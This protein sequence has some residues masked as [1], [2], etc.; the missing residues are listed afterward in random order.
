MTAGARASHA[1]A[2]AAA[3]GRGAVRISMRPIRRDCRASGRGSASTGPW[4]SPN[5]AERVGGGRSPLRPAVPGRAAPPHVRRSVG[6]VAGSTGGPRAGNTAEGTSSRRRVC[7]SRVAR[8]AVG[9]ERDAGSRH[10]GRL[11]AGDLRLRASCPRDAPRAVGAGVALGDAAPVGRQR[12]L[13]A[14]RRDRGGSERAA[15]VSSEGRQVPRADRA[16]VAGPVRCP[17]GVG[18]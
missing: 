15:R 10:G 16:S 13:R 7:A 3:R 18:V 4:A 6:V 12:P 1:A 9:S 17:R 14:G 8:G 2:V 11:G 5:R